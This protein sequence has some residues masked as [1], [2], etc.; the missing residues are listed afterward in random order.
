MSK[1][2]QDFDRI[3]GSADLQE[4]REQLKW[5]EMRVASLTIANTQLKAQITSLKNELADVLEDQEGMRMLFNDI[6][7][8]DDDDEGNHL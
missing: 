8:N 6:H 4:T 5:S 7:T 1:K 3:N 2:G